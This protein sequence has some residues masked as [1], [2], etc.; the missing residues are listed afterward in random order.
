LG[1]ESSIFR[2]KLTDTQETQRAEHSSKRGGADQEHP[3]G[4]RGGGQDTGGS[5]ADHPCDVERGG[6]QRH[7]VREITFPD[8]LRDEGMARR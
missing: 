3:A 5:R 7:C 8:Q 4:A 2:M 6:I 1:S